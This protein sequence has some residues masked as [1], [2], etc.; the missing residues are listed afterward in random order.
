MPKG[1]DS[2]IHHQ[3]SNTG[4]KGELTRS[5]TRNYLHVHKAHI[6]THTNHIYK[7]AAHP[8]TLSHK[9]GCMRAKTNLWSFL[10]AHHLQ[11]KH[12]C[13]LNFHPVGEGEFLW[14][15]ILGNPLAGKATS[16][17][18]NPKSFKQESPFCRG[19]RQGAWH[20][21]HVQLPT[22][23]VAAWG[24]RTTLDELVDEGVQA[25][26]VRELLGCLAGLMKWLI[27]VVDP[28]SQLTFHGEVA[29]G[30][31][32]PPP[33]AQLFQF[34]KPARLRPTACQDLVHVANPCQT[35]AP[36][37]LRQRRH[38][39]ALTQMSAGWSLG[40]SSCLKTQPANFSLCPVCSHGQLW[41]ACFASA[42]QHLQLRDWIRKEYFAGRQGIESILHILPF[43]CPL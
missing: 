11:K 5:E 20:P 35:S 3:T 12:L 40:C 33:S 2:S 32:F 26:A 21:P 18:R 41:T 8:N 7:Q 1:V 16:S 25:R 36:R 29:Q 13:H 27:I 22:C 17:T 30:R 19:A 14:H 37:G 43:I 23:R 28:F 6:H 39:K 34:H 4:R 10:R 42:C 24:M 9:T 15:S 31:A 38:F